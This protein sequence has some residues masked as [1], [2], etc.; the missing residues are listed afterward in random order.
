MGSSISI[1]GPG[2]GVGVL[3]GLPQ[4][5]I[6]IVSLSLA[7]LWISLTMCL[8]C[9]VWDGLLA[10][11]DMML[12]F[13]RPMFSD[14]G[15]LSCGGSLSLPFSFSFLLWFGP[16]CSY[17]PE[18]F[19]VLLFVSAFLLGMGLSPNLI[20]WVLHSLCKLSWLPLQ[21]IH[22]RGVS[23][24]WSLVGWSFNLHDLHHGVVQLL[25]ACENIPH[26]L[27]WYTCILFLYGVT[28]QLKLDNLTVLRLRRVSLSFSE[29]RLMMMEANCLDWMSSLEPSHFGGLNFF[30]LSYS[31]M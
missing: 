16:R 9:S 3:F 14:I 2:L 10:R 12:S 18:L 20:L 5:G 13:D 22:H 27:H 19:W 6:L 23:V 4:G 11:R 26:L 1:S 31:G 29:V 28:V 21:L 30:I 8:H 17:L 25:E 7:W 24:R 15:S